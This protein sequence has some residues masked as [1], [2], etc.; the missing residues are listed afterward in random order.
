MKT[1]NCQ[2]SFRIHIEFFDV[3][4]ENSINLQHLT[5]DEKVLDS[6]FETRFQSQSFT[7]SSVTRPLRQRFPSCSSS[8]F[9]SGDTKLEK[10]YGVLS[11][12]LFPNNYGEGEDC[13]W[14]ITAPAGYRLQLTFHWFGVEDHRY[15][16]RPGLCYDDY[17]EVTEKDI[18]LPKQ[19]PKLCG[20]KSLF[21]RVSSYERMWVSFISYKKANWPGFYATYRTICK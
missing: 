18:G 15:Y 17:V 19:F 2:V 16:N 20:C 11:S 1:T 9:C 8:D 10:P 13:V 4:L 5:M 14:V 6:K 7:T 12:P 21:T 3:D